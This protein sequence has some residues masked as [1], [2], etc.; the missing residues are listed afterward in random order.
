MSNGLIFIQIAAYRDAELLPTLRDC[1]AQAS[2]ALRLRFGIC[3]Q[4]G[5]EGTLG[6]FA[7]DP[8]VRV[9]EVP[10][11]RSRGAC[12]ARQQTQ[13]LFCDEEYTLQLDSHHRFVSG[14]DELLVEML[15]GLRGRGYA[16]PLLT[17]YAAIYDP[18][19]DPAGRTQVP[20]RLRFNGFSPGGPFAVMPETMDD[21]QSQTEPEPARFFSAHFAFTVGEFCRQVP[22]DPQLY[23]FGE[24]PSMAMRAFSQG[25]DLFHPHRVVL[26]HHYGRENSPKHWGDNRRWYFR[27]ELSMQRFRRLV[28]EGLGGISGEQSSLSPYGLG[29]LRGLGDYELYTGI[30]FELRGATRHAMKALRPPEPEPPV[31]LEA[32]RSLLLLPYEVVVPLGKQELAG[33][34]EQYDFVFV[35][36]HSTQGDEL[37]RYDLR[38]GE[39]EKALQHG[40]H[41]LSFLAAAEPVS[42]TVWPYLRHGGWGVKS[43]RPIVS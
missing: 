29:S 15:E 30:S 38:Q 27:N 8:R 26:W 41:R 20:L 17:S 23:F 33:S 37:V 14:W 19:K 24:E 40:C 31:N 12:W 9:F 1:V 10:A 21:Y 28:E 7:Q 6:E 42:W 25:Y 3:W 39:L 11:E 18:V 35:G 32:W 16:K 5:D 2:D 34:A 13:A 4:R 43:T 22:Y 36:A